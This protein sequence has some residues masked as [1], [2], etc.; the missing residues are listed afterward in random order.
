MLK[1]GKLFKSLLHHYIASSGLPIVTSQV[2]HAQAWPAVALQL[3]SLPV[4]QW[5]AW[6]LP[7]AA[8]EGV[9]PCHLTV[10]ARNA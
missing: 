8:D 2:S 1:L 3:S 9:L 4:L 5:A 10:Q 6:L 7:G